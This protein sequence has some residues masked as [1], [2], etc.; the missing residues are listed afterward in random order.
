[1]DNSTDF[2]KKLLES[3]Q[4][5]LT[6]E[7]YE[8]PQMGYSRILPYEITN[9]QDA[10]YIKIAVAGFSKEEIQISQDG[11]DTITVQNLVNGSDIYTSDESDIKK[12]SGDLRV[13]FKMRFFLTRKADIEEANIH[14]GLLVIKAVLDPKRAKE[15]FVKIG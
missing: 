10:I 2:I 4:K 3:Y 6:T 7:D 5:Q 14:E 1:M 9:A 12:T 8:Y 15:R 11:N 13:N